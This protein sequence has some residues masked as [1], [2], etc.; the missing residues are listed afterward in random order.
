MDVEIYKNNEG[1]EFTP[2]AVWIDKKGR[3]HVGRRAKERLEDDTENAHGEFK[4]NMGKEDSYLF[5]KSGRRMKPEELSAEVLKSLK[6]DVKQHTGEEV[7]ASVITVPAAF[8][9]SECEATKRA[10]ELA[11]FIESPLLQEPVAAA[12]AYG[13]QS[14]DDNVFWLVYDF[15]GGT[16]DAAV[17]RVRDECIE[18]VNHGGDNLLGGKLIDWAVVNELFVPALTKEY[19]LT[20][21]RQGVEQWRS[22]FAKLKAEAERAKILLSREQEADILIDSLGV[23]D[24]GEPM[25]FSFDLS[26]CDLERIAEPYVRRTIN[27]CKEVLVDK[28]LGLGDIEKVIL[29]GGTTLIP[30]LRDMLTDSNEGLGIPLESSI[31]PLT[32]VARGAAIEAGSQRWDP[33]IPPEADEFPI[34]LDYE[35]AG[36]DVEPPI[37][38]QVRK[39]GH[40]DYSGF[41]V[42][43][44][45]QSVGS[46]WRSGK[47]PLKED[48]T[49]VTSLWAEKGKLN[50]YE[51]VLMDAQGTA[52]RTVPSSIPYRVGTTAPI[53]PLIHSVGVA[54][55]NNETDFFFEKGAALPQRASKTHRNVKEVR[56]NHEGDLINIPV[57]EG[58]NRT[59][60]YRNRVSGC[61]RIPA[62]K[63]KR[64]VPAGSEIDITL[65]IDKS[66]LLRA[67]AYIPILDEE[68]EKIIGLAK[69]A[70]DPDELKTDVEREK[71]RLETLTQKTIET[72]SEKARAI[73]DKIEEEQIT[74]EIESALA[75]AV[76]VAESADR[77]RN[78]LLDLQQLLDKI[79]DILEWPSLCREADNAIEN[80]RQVVEQYGQPD[81]QM[82]FATIKKEIDNAK[83]QTGEADLLRPKVNQMVGL[84][85]KILREQPDWWVAVFK[86]LETKVDI[87]RDRQ[88]AEQLIA[89]GRKAILEGNLPALKDV[90]TQLLDLLPIDD[91][92]RVWDKRDHEPGTQR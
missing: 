32:V 45:N 48:G 42:E 62:D 8:E 66:Q 67:K 61:L 27:I 40:E 21:F 29:A 35:P 58:E 75:T 90:V 73:L 47:I 63:I 18:V 22:A 92:Q 28:H 81:D 57:V 7:E 70:V 43:F 20:D 72:G 5:A 83:S 46:E 86:D 41:T 4:Q 71:T 51:I 25:E 59:R 1:A 84:M 13:F 26:K 91:K 15:G 55:A 79:D 80:T 50:T 34:D 17:L 30:L 74:H 3:T 44:I 54:M 33:Q 68:Y 69:Q 65:D 49:F 14:Q 31:Y 88:Q 76:D 12:M 19:K 87:M 9:L 78:R 60:A 77:C 24:R 82:N 64:T 23:D 53:I 2:S 36:P 11:G 39:D 37:G 89:A 38:G 52:L 16:F 56:A 85:Y 6:A 10:A